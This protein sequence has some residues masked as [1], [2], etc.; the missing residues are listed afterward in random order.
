MP[1]SSELVPSPRYELSRW[2]FLRLLALVYLIAFASL[3]PQL[4]GLV[5]E[6]G[7]LPAADLL[8]RAGEFYGAAAWYEFPTLAWLGAGDAG[9]W[10]SAGQA[11]CSRCWPP[12]AW[13]RC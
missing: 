1:T 4:R 9:C 10:R 11:S 3:A 13:R 8:E 5:G 6:Q 7:L 12:P 2:L